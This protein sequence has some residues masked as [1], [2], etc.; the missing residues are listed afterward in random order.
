RRTRLPW[1]RR[2]DHREVRGTRKDPGSFSRPR[3]TGG[4]GP[5]PEGLCDECPP[6]TAHGG[7]LLVRFRCKTL[8][9]AT[10]LDSGGSTVPLRARGIPPTCFTGP[11]PAA[12]VQTVGARLRAK[13]IRDQ[14]RS[15]EEDA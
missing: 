11:T 5:R 4:A 8:P 1:P 13:G 10:R 9:R 7:H 3:T 6:A 2:H 15:H 14:G 12:P